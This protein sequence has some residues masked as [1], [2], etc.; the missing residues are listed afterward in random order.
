M[1]LIWWRRLSNSARERARRG[2]RIAFRP[3]LEALEGRDLPAPVW[4]GYAQNAQHTA[5]SSVSSQSLQEIRW[6]QVIDQNPPF[7]GND[8]L[9][10]YGSPLIT[11]ANTVIIPEKT[12]STGGFQVEARSGTDGGLIWRQTTDY[13]EPPHGWV[14]PFAPVLTPN[15]RLFFAGAGGTLYYMDNVDSPAA[16]APV[17][18]AFYGLTNYQANPSAYNAAVYIDTPLTSDSLGNIY[19]GY[20]VTGSTPLGLQSGIARIHIDSGTG[21]VTGIRVAAST[22]AGDSSISKVVQNC[23]PALSNNGGYVYVAVN[24]SSSHGYLLELNSSTLATVATV[25]LKDPISGRDALLSDDGTASPLVGPDGDVYYGVLE[26][27]FPHNHDRGF[28]LHFSG[29]LGTT[30]TPGDFGWDDTPSI[31]PL[32]M[33]PSYTA[34]TGTTYLLFSKYNNYADVGGN[35]QNRIAVL[36]P[37]TAATSIVGNSGMM[38]EVETILGPTPNTG[39]S[40]VREWCINSAVVDPGTDSVLANSEDGNL[41]RWDLGSNS[42]TE[43]VTL[44][45]G[46]GE[47][48]TPT[49]IGADGTVYAINDAILFAVGRPS[50]VS[51]F[52]VPG[53]MVASGN[54]LTVPLPATGPSGATL[55]YSGVAVSP[56]Y[57]LWQQYGLHS[58]GNFYFNWGGRQEKWIQGTASGANQGWYFLLPDGEFYSWDGSSQAT[59]TLIATIPTNYYTY[60][61]L[62]YNNPRGGSPSATVTASGNALTITPNAGFTGLFYVR[63]TVSDGTSSASQLIPVTVTAA[64]H[65][66]TLASI[67]NASISRGSSYTVALSASDSD[68]DPISYGGSAFSQAYQ[69]AQGYGFFF[70]GN[71]FLNYGGRQERWFQGG[72]GAWYFILPSGAVYQWDGTLNQATGTLIATLDNSYY[73]NLALL[74]NATPGATVGVSGNLLTVTPDPSFTGVLTVT[75]TAS[76][77]FTTVTQLFT[78]TVS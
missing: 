37:N 1:L 75:A 11:Q 4:G 8:L 2:R 61:N 52:P 54:S 31:V 30:K 14:L 12:T 38:K 25:R 18:V 43:V 62:L 26:N 27:P 16:T 78:L 22:A 15:N 67:P 19:F 48:Y 47:A 3:R 66:P 49:S 9:V 44:T 51:L 39:L 71:D 33:V 17:Q 70:G 10:H 42:L 57:A 64:D 7:S 23:A 24:D 32:S 74:Y 55:T 13:S 41:Y 29:D 45:S 56:G 72:A 53:Q 36:D 20:Q 46:I 77:G 50:G 58:D 63:A 59:G 6:Q 34:P 35:G 65:A 40:G 28:L 21:V 5:D 69:L 73:T 68:G 60:L 76:D